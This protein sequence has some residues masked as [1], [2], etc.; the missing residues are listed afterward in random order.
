MLQVSSLVELGISRTEDQTVCKEKRCFSSVTHST[1][2][3]E[4]MQPCVFL[5]TDHYPTVH[6]IC[7][8]SSSRMC[9]APIKAVSNHLYIHLCAITRLNIVIVLIYWA[10]YTHIFLCN[11]WLTQ[12]MYFNKINICIPWKHS[13]TYNNR[14]ELKDWMVVVIMW[15]LYVSINIAD[16]QNHN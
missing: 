7:A 5:L 2:C 3:S 11:I 13:L 4:V 6:T 16:V 1:W 10:I 8:S 12:I 14:H 9:A 15:A